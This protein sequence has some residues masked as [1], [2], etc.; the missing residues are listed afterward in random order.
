M[1]ANVRETVWIWTHPLEL[2]FQN[3]EYKPLN[4]G[5]KTTFVWTGSMADNVPKF[6]PELYDDNTADSP[7][8]VCTCIVLIP[9]FPIDVVFVGAASSFNARCSFSHRT[10]EPAYAI[11]PSSAY[12]G[13]CFG[14]NW[15][16]SV[17]NSPFSESI[18]SW[19]VF[20]RRLQPS[21][22]VQVAWYACRHICASS[23]PDC[24]PKH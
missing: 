3:G 4:A 14:P 13:F 23:E 18:I 16:A 10:A 5:T 1:W 7:R 11:A 2:C 20:T 19:P 12:D 22:Y 6:D 17:V 15:N 24:S 21:S 9:P 8:N